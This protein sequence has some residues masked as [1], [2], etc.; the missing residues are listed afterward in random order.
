MQQ[1]HS[2]RW[3]RRHRLRFLTMVVASPAGYLVALCVAATQMSEDDIWFIA[4]LGG[5][6]GAV[7]GLLLSG[8]FGHPGRKGWLLSVAASLLSP[9]LGGAVVG[10]VFSPGG[11]TVLGAVMPLMTFTRFS[12]F[13]L[14][15]AC[16]VT[17]HLSI[18]YLR[19]RFPA[20]DDLA[21]KPEHLSERQL[22]AFD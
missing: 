13:S 1:F 15:L 20:G 7:A 4:L 11:G 8:L 5:F 3:L 14:W 12:S 21:I 10:S 6:S 16:L 22:S 18:R 9:S 2:R 19:L 17:V